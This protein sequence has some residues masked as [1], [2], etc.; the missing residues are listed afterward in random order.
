[1]CTKIID[2]VDCLEGSAVVSLHIQ[3]LLASHGQHRRYRCQVTDK[4]R[5]G[6]DAANLLQ[7]VRVANLIQEQIAANTM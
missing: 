4:A 2:N 5:D 1:L 3:F 6:S 7:R